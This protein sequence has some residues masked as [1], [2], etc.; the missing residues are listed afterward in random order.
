MD[1]EGPDGYYESSLRWFIWCREAGTEPW[2]SGHYARG[3]LYVQLIRGPQ[4]HLEAVERMIRGRWLLTVLSLVAL[5]TLT[6]APIARAEHGDNDHHG[7]AK[8]HEQAI[9][10]QLRDEDENNDNDKD[11]DDVQAEHRLPADLANK[12]V[13]ALNFQVAKL[14]TDEDKDDDDAAA[15]DIDHVRAISLATLTSRFNA[16][17]AALLTSAVTNNSA[18]VQTFLNSGTADAKAVDAALANAGVAQSSVLA[19]LP[20]SDETLLV[21]TA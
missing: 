12:L 17:D 11:K 1:I 13:E 20:M 6:L 14:S 8:G 21:L 19:I 18:A 16:A 2:A 3:S 10:V 4:T 7:L 9:R 5:S 15:L